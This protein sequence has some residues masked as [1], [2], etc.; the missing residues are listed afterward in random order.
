M[1]DPQESGHDGTGYAEGAGRRGGKRREA[2]EPPSH[3]GRGNWAEGAS[4]SDLRHASTEGGDRRRRE[5]VALS[6]AVFGPRIKV[7]SLG[8]CKESPES[9]SVVTFR[10]DHLPPTPIPEPLHTPSHSAYYWRSAHPHM[11]LHFLAAPSTKAPGLDSGST[12]ERHAHG[13]VDGSALVDGEVTARRPS[14]RPSS[15][16]NIT[17]LTVSH[18]FTVLRCSR[19][20]QPSCHSQSTH[21]Q[22]LGTAAVAWHRGWAAPDATATM[23]RSPAARTSRARGLRNVLKHVPTAAISAERLGHIQGGETEFEAAGGT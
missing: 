12:L 3:G 10:S 19:V 23:P 17:C 8:G 7:G 22:N 9:Q 13:E 18:H 20:S 14:S 15:E 1:G 21:S 2:E 6:P 4:E 16:Q 5:N 11:L